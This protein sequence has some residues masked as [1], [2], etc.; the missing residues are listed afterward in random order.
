M[1]AV[2][3][4]PTKTAQHPASACRRLCVPR[5]KAPGP[6]GS[7]RTAHQKPALSAPRRTAPRPAH[8]SSRRHHPWPC[9]SAPRPPENPPSTAACRRPALA[10]QDSAT[11]G[12]APRRP[13]T[14]VIIRPFTVRSAP[15][16]PPSTAACRRPAPAP[17]DSATT[18]S[19]PPAPGNLRHHLPPHRAARPQAHQSLPISRPS[20]CYH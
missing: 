14:S 18:G 7:A 5:T 6:C 11:T 1:I 13:G 2:R 9:G 3:T 19:A 12:W 17:Q 16:A 4:R 20:A 10:R 15:R 8:Q